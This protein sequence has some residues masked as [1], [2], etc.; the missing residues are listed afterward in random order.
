MAA[1]RFLMTWVFL[2]FYGNFRMLHYS[3]IIKLL[4]SVD[5]RAHV[6]EEFL[7]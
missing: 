4:L 1:E 6:D 5:S 2:G 7:A 3:F